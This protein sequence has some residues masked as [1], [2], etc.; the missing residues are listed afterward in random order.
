MV[1]GL[2]LGA[3]GGC[4]DLGGN[5]PPAA[6]LAGTTGMADPQGA[7]AP[8]TGR[9]GTLDKTFGPDGTGIA[10]IRFGADDDGRFTALDASDGRIVATG[11]GTGGLGEVSMATMRFTADGR[12]DPAWNAGAVVRTT[13]GTSS[14]GDE[15][16]ASAV[17]RQRDG[18]II[19]IGTNHD[20]GSRPPCP[21]T[22]DLAVARLSPTDGAVDP[23]FGA[24]SGDAGRATIDLGGDEVVHDGLVLGTDA[25]VAVGAKDGQLLVARLTANGALDTSFAAPAGYDRVVR[26][27]ASRAD[28]VTVDRAGGIVVAG[29]I[30]SD[31]PSA[32]L[33]IRYLA[34]GAHDPRF[35]TGGE[36]ILSGPASEESVALRAHGARLYLASSA[37]GAGGDR[38]RVRRLLADGSLDPSFGSGGVAEIPDRAALDMVVFP[39][40]RIAV[41]TTQSTVVRLTAGGAIDGRFGTGGEVAVSF[42]D[43]S[44]PGGL[45]V[46]SAH[47]LLV[48]GGDAGGTPGPGTFGVVERIWM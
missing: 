11:A 4:G 18:R 36:V 43:A 16:I 27:T 19:L 38:V 45:Q 40:G 3:S 26:G 10:R 24:G 25:I 20:A 14:T 32:L 29:T 47:Q 15:A 37:S 39:D 1:V 8:V 22:S 30:M 2:L 12:P 7:A 33:V 13:F 28:A 48:A 44:V 31:G 6:E 21:C 46:Y 34:S 42:G 5:E 41:L 17:G 9:P 23:S 35:G